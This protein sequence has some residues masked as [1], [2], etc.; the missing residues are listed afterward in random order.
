MDSLLVSAMLFSIKKI[1]TFFG[2]HFI[3]FTLQVLSD[4]QSDHD[5]DKQVSNQP[6]VR[7]IRLNDNHEQLV[8]LWAGNDSRHIIC[9]AKNRP[10]SDE[11][12]QS[13]SVYISSDGGDSYKRSN[14]F[15][16]DNKEA[17]ISSFY[18]SSASSQISF[19]VDTTNQYLFVS[20]NYGKSLI[21]VN[22]KFKP[23][24][25]MLH[26][27]ES[28][29]LL[30]FDNF[31]NQLWISQDTGQTWKYLTNNVIQFAWG[32]SLLDHPN[33][34][35][36]LKTFTANHSSLISSSDFLA[37]SSTLLND[38]NKFI[39]KGDYLFAVRK[40]QV[41]GSKN[42]HKKVQLWISVKRKSFE[43]ALLPDLEGKYPQDFQVIDVDK[44]F[45]MIS[46]IYHDSSAVLMICSPNQLHF[47]ISLKDALF[48][49]PNADNYNIIHKS[50]Q[51]FTD[52]YKIAGL[53]GIYIANYYRNRT[54]NESASVITFDNG[55]NWQPLP[56]PF[57]KDENQIRC[58]KNHDCSLHLT[59][60]LNQ[61]AAS[62]KYPPI[63]SKLSSLG[64]I[65]SSGVVNSSYQGTPKLFISSDAGVSWRQALNGDYLFEIGA[66]GAIIMAVKHFSKAGGTNQ[67]IYSLDYGYSWKVIE[68]MDNNQTL[69]I[70]NLLTEP[71]GRSAVFTL[72]GALSNSAKHDW[73][74]VKINMT[75]IFKPK[76]SES[77]YQTWSLQSLSETKCNLGK[78]MTF[79][80]PS[81]NFSC[82]N[83]KNLEKP[84][85]VVIC[86]CSR[87][88]YHC[89]IGYT[90]DE[91]GHCIK[92]NEQNEFLSNQNLETC[93]LNQTVYKTQGYRKIFGN[94]CQ[95]GQA[96]SYE[97][98]L[99][100]CI[101]QD[102]TTVTS[103]EKQAHGNTKMDDGLSAYPIVIILIIG[104]TVIGIYFFRNQRNLL[105]FK[106]NY[107]N[108]RSAGNRYSVNASF[109]KP[110]STFYN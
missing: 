37:S 3:A 55:V 29:K 26:P 62:I 88:D 47:T 109:G 11:S 69:K 70:Y 23:Q 107:F 89:D 53:E 18:I 4:N 83:T 100:P 39:L 42:H 46:T 72:F 34:L 24:L 15:T 76:C 103:T 77:D 110:F 32:S 80:R 2:L 19:F 50:V 9:L 91:F 17:V 81:A 58:E 93:S 51:S 54:K 104:V 105:C 59:Q 102:S 66:F 5:N 87:A 28:S 36:V 20:Q 82:L 106:K 49:W 43:L 85:K 79:L 57:D 44:K 97:P 7:V 13:S 90:N 78:K 92:S 75:S 21:S 16:L 6:V 45:I 61:H 38:V 101:N 52:I 73:I 27:N 25:L 30:A 35:F 63:L 84:V 94:H 56:L 108:S 22:L 64:L 12:K 60:R 99:V 98:L 14:V 68:F 48:S 41:F 31:N 8:L 40:S 95:G 74:I 33:T 65:V 71:G 67:A 10:N 1:V 86:P 96:S